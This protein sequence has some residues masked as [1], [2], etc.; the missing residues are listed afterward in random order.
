MHP[1]SWTNPKLMVKVSK[2]STTHWFVGYLLYSEQQSADFNSIINTSRPTANVHQSFISIFSLSQK[3]LHDAS[4]PSNLFAQMGKFHCDCSEKLANL[5]DTNLVHVTNHLPF[6][7]TFSVT[8]T[9]TSHIYQCFVCSTDS[10]E[11]HQI[12]FHNCRRH[13]YM[14]E[15]RHVRNY[16]L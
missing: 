7:I 3:H 6:P 13:L 8:T 5:L 12:S 1:K 4:V 11:K 16:Q 14:L 10:S 2:N 9:R 15:K